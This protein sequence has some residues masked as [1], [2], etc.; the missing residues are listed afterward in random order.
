MANIDPKIEK[1]LNEELSASELTAFKAELAADK[2]LNIAVKEELMIRDALEA[3]EKA[4]FKQ[5]LQQKKQA[6]VVPIKKKTRTRWMSIAAG[7]ALLLIPTFQIFQHTNTRI[8]N[9]YFEKDQSI[10]SQL[11][12]PDEVLS[13]FDLAIV[14]YKKGDYDVA[15]EKLSAIKDNTQATYVLGHTYL[16]SKNHTKAIEQFQKVINSKNPEYL[17]KAEWYL[18]LATLQT[19]KLNA[20]FYALLENIIEQDNGYSNSAKSIQKDLNSIWKIK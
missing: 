6:K 18:L 3:H 7:F 2:A 19:G 16:L 8:A 11:L 20:E 14:A 5:Q 17:E 13:P 1:Y 9:Q 4:R 10:T 15:A 12:S